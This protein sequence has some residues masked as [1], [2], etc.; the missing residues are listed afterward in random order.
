AGY[1]SGLENGYTEGKASEDSY[2]ENMAD[3]LGTDED[4][5]K[6]RYVY[7]DNFQPREYMLELIK[8]L[9]EEAS[10]QLGIFSDQ[11]NW[12]Y[13]LDEMYDF[14]KYF[15]Y[16][17]IS[18][19]KGYTKHD[20]EFYD[21]PAKETGISPEKILLVDDKQRVVDNA[22]EHG[23]KAHLFTSIKD[24]YRLFYPGNNKL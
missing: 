2:W 22:R 1:R 17:C 11:T 15:D 6:Y 24:S 21:I 3:L 10:F 7:L 5:K 4:L 23:M 8:K 14:F 16:F 18:Y 12:I 19:D 13:E 20:R 9:D